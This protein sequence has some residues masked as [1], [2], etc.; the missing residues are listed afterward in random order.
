MYALAAPKQ[1]QDPRV[2]VRRSVVD[3]MTRLS[4]SLY[5]RTFPN[6]CRLL[7][8]TSD[9]RPIVIPNSGPSLYARRVG[10][11][12]RDMSRPARNVPFAGRRPSS[13]LRDLTNQP[14]ADWPK[15]LR[16][17]H[18]ILVDELELSNEE[19]MAILLPSVYAAQACAQAIDR[20]AQDVRASR[21]RKRLRKIFARMA[22]CAH[23]LP[24]F[25]RHALDR[26][27]CS[28]LRH[29]AI[30]SER[31][32]SL[33]EDLVK[34]FGTSPKTE[35]SLTIL[36]AVTS[37]LASAIVVT[38]STVGL[39]RRFTEAA[40]LLREDYSALPALD[41][42]Q[43]ESA[44]THLSETT[45]DNFDAADVCMTMSKALDRNGRDEISRSIADLITDYV[46]EVA[47]VWR[48]HGLRPARARDNLD[49]SYQGRFHRF[50]EL[51]LT[52]VVDP[53]SRRHDGDQH[54]MLVKRRKSHDQLPQDVRRIVGAGLQ[55]SDVEWLVADDHLK[56]ALAAGSKNDP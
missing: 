51:I 31:M 23:R 46:A 49:K 41:Q 15:H 4:P 8:A 48:Q 37:G 20:K 52:S 36:R 12:Q 55:R 54:E 6:R 17:A 30:D 34:A 44:L 47:N 9:S 11:G 25:R 32:E 28:I 56:R 53:W 39:R 13:R 29:E 45:D 42:R 7:F 50:V 1:S 38:A 21:N 40:I 2:E 14:I 10:H 43:V 26:K 22:K 19:A 16:W 24:A 3:Q 33:I 5:R 35:P 18:A 27:V